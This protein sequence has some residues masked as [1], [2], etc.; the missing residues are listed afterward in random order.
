MRLCGT[1]VTCLVLCLE[2]SCAAT[3]NTSKADSGAISRVTA[4]TACSSDG[5]Q[6]TGDAPVCT[7]VRRSVTCT[8]IGGRW[9]CGH[10]PSC[11]ATLQLAKPDIS[12]G[13]GTACE[14]PTLAIRCDGSSVAVSGTCRCVYG[15][16]WSCDGVVDTACDAGAGDATGE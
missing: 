4:G 15:G 13:M 10:C 6:A 2:V 16:P 9:D 5:S 8:C 11:A 7:D 1:L 3:P 14:G 12:C